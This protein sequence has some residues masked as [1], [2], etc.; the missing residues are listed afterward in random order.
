[1]TENQTYYVSGLS[2]A[3]EIIK[4]CVDN[5]LKIGNKY[6]V[7]MQSADNYTINDLSIEEMVLYRINQKKKCSY[8]FT[9]NYDHPTADLVLYSQ[10]GIMRRVFDSYKEAESNLPLYL[11]YLL[12]RKE[13][14]GKQPMEKEKYFL[15]NGVRIK[16]SEHF[17]ENG[18][19]ITDI[20]KEAVRR[21]SNS[22][23]KNLL[24]AT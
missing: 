1:M 15:H 11:C 12:E 8:C 2:D 22:L 21:D 20:I 23:R 10:R 6:Y 18:K 24:P 5:G 9:R 17:K 7:I 14:Y 13:R 3:L 19:P 16:I 4:E